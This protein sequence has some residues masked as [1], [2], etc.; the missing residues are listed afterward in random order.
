MRATPMGSEPASSLRTAVSPQRSSTSSTRRRRSFSRRRRV[1]KYARSATNPPPPPCHSTAARTLSS[2]VSHPNACTRW[3]VRRSPRRARWVLDVDVTSCPASSTSP[4]FG[5][6]TPEITSKSVV[7]PAPFGPMIPR[8]SPLLA[9]M[10]TALSTVM[11]PKRTVMPRRVEHQLVAGP[12]DVLVLL[13]CDRHQSF[14]PWRCWAD[15]RASRTTQTPRSDAVSHAAGPTRRPG[16]ADP[17]P[18]VDSLR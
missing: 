12:W 2:T 16:S 4:S 14:P 15:R 9:S 10:L 7:L 13:G 17:G 3:K 6:R 18:R 8:T 5:A 11:P 1:G